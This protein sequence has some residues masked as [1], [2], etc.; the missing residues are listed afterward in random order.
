VIAEGHHTDLLENEPRYAEVLA[1]T[2]LVETVADEDEEMPRRSGFDEMT[3]PTTGD[4][5]VELRRGDL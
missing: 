1:T 4:I 5:A 3:D 2:V